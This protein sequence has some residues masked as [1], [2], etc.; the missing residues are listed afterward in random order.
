MSSYHLE[1]LSR[2]LPKEKA[3]DM[4]N[5]FFG[6]LTL[7]A[8][9]NIDKR[10]RLVLRKEGRI[11]LQTMPFALFADLKETT[12]LMEYANG[13]RP[14][15]LDWYYDIFL[16]TYDA[17]SE[18]DSKVTIGKGGDITI[19]EERVAVTTQ[20]LIEATLEKQKKNYSTKQILDTY[21]N[22]L[23][24]QGYIDRVE[25]VMDR[26]RKIHYPVI[27]TTRNRK[28]FEMNQSNNFSQSAKIT[29]TDPTNN[30]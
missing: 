16:E 12:F 17:K 3:L 28:L 13:V 19:K 6:F 29:I 14:Y 8:I 20:D 22:P 15:I 23:V 24:N 18:P 25:S 4:T 26:R 11:Q 21:I 1:K 7:L 2:C 5:R 9:V 30:I 10:P 27:A